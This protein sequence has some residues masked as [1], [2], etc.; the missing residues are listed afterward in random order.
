MAPLTL[1]DSDERTNMKDQFTPQARVM[2]DTISPQMQ[3]KILNNVWCVHCS[4]GTS[5][6]DFEGQEEKGDLLLRVRCAICEGKVARLI[7]SD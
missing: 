5:I 7:E 1:I 6:T 2:W 4:K 3:E